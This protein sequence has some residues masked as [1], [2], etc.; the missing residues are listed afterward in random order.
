MGSGASKDTK[1]KEAALPPQRPSYQKRPNAA[2]IEAIREGESRQASKENSP[3]P[4]RKDVGDDK[5]KVPPVLREDSLVISRHIA[6]P[7]QE[8]PEPVVTDVDPT[9]PDSEDRPVL[10]EEDVDENSK[11]S[12]KPKYQ[13]HL[14]QDVFNLKK[15]LPPIHNVGA[16]ASSIYDAAEMEKFDPLDPT[17]EPLPPGWD[18]DYDVKGKVYFIDHVHKRTTYKDPRKSKAYKEQA[19]KKRE[20]WLK[21]MLPDTQ[22]QK[23]TV[24]RMKL[25]AGWEM[26]IMDNGRPYFIDTA[27]KRTTWIDPRLTHLHQEPD[28]LTETDTVPSLSMKGPME[29][30]KDIEPPVQ[31]KKPLNERMTINTPEL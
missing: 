4:I 22:N 28:S 18:F 24:E 7:K 13:K 17:L 6:P 26:R 27:T 8:I 11:I 25:P 19:L 10:E 5:G 14:G 9:S 23:S 30:T 21:T 3:V 29:K 15:P 31:Y 16:S 2:G 12:N 20:S 1:V